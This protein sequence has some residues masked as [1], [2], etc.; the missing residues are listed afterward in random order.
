MHGLP[1][2]NTVPLNGWAAELTFNP[3]RRLGLAANFSGD[4][5]SSLAIIDAFTLIPTSPG[6]SFVTIPTVTT[7]LTRVR[8]ANHSL[9]LG[10]EFRLVQ[11]RRTAVSFT[12]GIGAARSTLNNPVVFFAT[13]GQTEPKL[14]PSVGFA[15][16]GGVSVDVRLTEHAAYRVV[17]FRFTAGNLDFGWQRSVQL[18]T[19]LVFKLAR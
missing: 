3:T 2:S 12:A 10:P 15:T 9:L 1:S 5:G 14:P 13:A 16:G 4:Y 18:G 19:G 17:E 11:N 6:S 8:V 7:G